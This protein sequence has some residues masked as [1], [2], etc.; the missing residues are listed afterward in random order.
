MNLSEIVKIYLQGHHILP[1]KASGLAYAPA[2]VALI[3][4]WGKRDVHLNLPMNSSLSLALGDRGALTT[5]S[6]NRDQNQD[7]VS[8]NGENVPLHLPFARKIIDYL[9][10]LDPARPYLCIETELT[11]PSSAGL[12]SSAAG[13]AAL[14]LAL[15]DLC[16]WCLSKT[17]LSRLA[18]LGSGSAARSLWSGF[19]EWHKGSH[20]DGLDSFAEPVMAELP[21]FNLGLLMLTTNPKPL[22][23]REG[24]L[25]TTQTSPLYSSWPTTAENDLNDLKT[26]IF[27][28]DVERIGMIAEQNALAMHA[29]MM[30]A[31]PALVYSLPQTWSA[32]QQIW[33]LRTQNNVPVYFTQDAGP[34]LKLLFPKEYTPLLQQT[35]PTLEIVNLMGNGVAPVPKQQAPLSQASCRS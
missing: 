4:Y 20:P 16:A 14:V 12:A 33:A 17:A 31:R 8:L 24:M 27:H 34:N 11:I 29:T 21:A 9:N 26:A 35:F 10:L 15:A 3:K 1:V 32:I 30:A 23:S 22:S 13:F 25:L 5:I 6:V 19:V 18:R 2:N 7:V 28:Q